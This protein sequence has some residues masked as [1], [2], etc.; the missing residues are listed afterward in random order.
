MKM[1]NG[2]VLAVL[3]ASLFAVRSRANAQV[4]AKAGHVLAADAPEPMVFDHKSA[5]TNARKVEIQGVSAIRPEGK[6]DRVEIPFELKSARSVRVWVRIH[7][8]WAS[9]GDTFYWQIDRREEQRCTSAKEGRSDWLNGLINVWRWSKA[10]EV[11]LKPGPHTLVL[12]NKGAVGAS[13]SKIAL[14][15]SDDLSRLAFL[16]EDLNG[17]V[18]ALTK[19]AYTFDGTKSFLSIESESFEKITGIVDECGASGGKAV[20][21]EKD[22]ARDIV[23]VSIPKDME[24]EL[25]MR[26]YMEAKHFVGGHSIEEFWN[27]CYLEVDG[28][29]T[30]AAYGTDRKR[31][32]WVQAGRVPFKKGLHT[33][34]TFKMG[35]PAR[36]DRIVLYAGKDARNE[37]WYTEQFAETLPFG[38][39]NVVAANEAPKVSNWYPLGELAAVSKLG[40]QKGAKSS[41]YANTVEIAGDG[42]GV[43]V[44]GHQLGVGLGEAQVHV[45]RRTPQQ[46]IMYVKGDASGA[47]LRGLFCDQSGEVFEAPFAA[48]VDWQG[49]RLTALNL[50]DAAATRHEGGDGNGVIDFPVT[51]RYLIIQKRKPG[52]CRIAFEEPKFSRELKVR[53]RPLKRSFGAGEKLAFVLSLVND[54]DD[55]RAHITYTLANVAKR[56]KSV[57]H[58]TSPLVSVA[59]GKSAAFALELPPAPQGLYSLAYA[60]NHG[61]PQELNFCVGDPT[62]LKFAEHMTALEKQCGA[63]RFSPDGKDKPLLLSG[64]PVNPEDIGKVYG[65]E[66]GFAVLADGIDVCSWEYASKLGYGDDRI[67]PRGFDLSDEAGWPGIEVP[68]G[69]LAIDPRLGRFKFAQ[70]NDDDVS[71]VGSAVTGF[72]K[73]AGRFSIDGEY[74][75][76]NSGEGCHTIVDMSDPAKPVVASMLRDY[77][78]HRSPMRPYKGHAFMASSHRGMVV[79]DLANPYCPGP[80]RT[81]SLDQARQ[82]KI[83]KVF[84]DKDLAYMANGLI[85]D[86]RDPVDPRVVREDPVVK[87]IGLGYFLRGAPYAYGGLKDGRMKAYDLTD[88]RSP[89]VVGEFDFAGGHVADVAEGTM[90]ALHGNELRVYDAADVTSPKL[91]LKLIVKAGKERAESQQDPTTTVF[92]VAGGTRLASA[93]LA[94]GR[95]YIVDT[96]KSRRDTAAGPHV[97]FSRIYTI[98][99]SGARPVVKHVYQETLPS[100]YSFVARYRDDHLVVDDYCYGL[101]VFSIKDRDQPV[102]VAKILTAGEVRHGGYVSDSGFA[103]LSNTFDGVTQVFD[104]RNPETPRRVGELVDGR[105]LS[106]W[107]RFSGAGDYVYAPEGYEMQI[108]DI[109]TPT[110]PERVGAFLSKDGKPFG[111]A[112]A[113]KGNLACVTHGYT[114]YTYDVTSPASPKLLGS[115]KTTGS[116][117]Y[118][119]GTACYTL[120]GL[121]HGRVSKVDISDP[122]DPKLLATFDMANLYPG[123]RFGWGMAVQG[124]Y[125]Y[126]ATGGWRITEP[127]LNILDVRG[128]K[129]SLVKRIP[130]PEEMSPYYWSGGWMDA[131]LCGNILSLGNYGFV[132]LFDISEPLKPK[133][134]Y[135]ENVGC[136]WSTGVIRGGYLYQANLMGLYIYSLPMCSQVPEGEVASRRP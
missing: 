132:M 87:E 11:S 69:T 105:C 34:S 101:R 80:F 14:A 16:G 130:L 46:F 70:G 13:F 76:T 91:K 50:I 1:R 109:S 12:A 92:T 24:L 52:P 61:H 36:F 39:A 27:G 133:L 129:I 74:L 45:P 131:T 73:H 17:T 68:F 117:P 103:V 9:S 59:K 71:L 54:G 124:D 78:F 75:Y 123:G 60:V 41:P 48:A 25:W 119:D 84:P 79:F 99:A 42:T 65:G 29:M 62:K 58:G 53:G 67:V 96:I 40:W 56:T 121:F 81:M 28:E 55:N 135:R 32:R 10:G 5:P 31:W 93:C 90:V 82:S 97:G 128:D 77:H 120:A 47:G 102:E 2:T 26:V 111:G 114:L 4:A 100:G 112:V 122:T 22:Y 33:I 95:V 43:L 20:R 23:T 125:V 15:F 107:T 115:V 64:K 37:S 57:A 134:I 94:K 127:F 108:V 19:P 35:E 6:F 51:L 118:I 63:Y 21:R 136:A 44:L 106:Y 88:P 104:V 110:A 3:L 85:L 49:W 30:G 83:S 113:A 86:I 7:S 8:R 18:R 98:D 89:K 72:G 126:A 66:G 38:I 116:R